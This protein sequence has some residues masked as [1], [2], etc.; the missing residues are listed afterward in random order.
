MKPTT[1]QLILKQ[2][3]VISQELKE[4]NRLKKGFTAIA[5]THPIKKYPD[6]EIFTHEI[7]I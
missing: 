7:E 6:N 5:E 1:E 3:E 2:L 4:M